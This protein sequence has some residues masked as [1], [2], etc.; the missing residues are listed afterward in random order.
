MKIHKLYLIIIIS[1]L[2]TQIWALSVSGRVLDSQQK[3]I[4]EAVV[5]VGEFAVFTNSEG[6]FHLRNIPAKQKILIHKIGYQDRYL[7]PQ[8]ISMSIRLER[9]V[10][11]AEG[12]SVS[13]R[14]QQRTAL[15]SSDKI[16]IQNSDT[17]SADL[18]G[19][20][21][22]YAD[23]QVKGSSLLGGKQTIK[24]GGNKSKHT[25]VM[26]DGVALNING[27]DF[28]ISSI[29]LAL[30]DKIEIIPNNAG[31]LG[32]SGAIGGIVNIITRE[33]LAYD[34]SA[35]KKYLF[36]NKNSWQSGSFDLRKAQT[37]ISFSRSLWQAY[38]LISRAEAEND[39]GY[40]NKITESNET[41]ANNASEIIDGALRISWQT[42][43]FQS[44]YNLIYQDYYKELPGAI[45]T[46]SMFDQSYKEGYT[47]RQ[48]LNLSYRYKM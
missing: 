37:Q 8:Q 34:A 40:Y 21:K 20:L 28:D 1:L 33:Q 2:A 4:S 14:R 19:L 5:S 38:A 13:Q 6:I 22:Q 15:N 45:S 31:A 35:G 16:V 3:P 12:I 36:S 29:P 25:L 26:L 10:L 9:D 18:A 30:I 39:F 43:H 24:L 47:L 46:L 42:E 11:P 41:R 27:E 32:G 7:L 23:I 44:K 48:H 17:G